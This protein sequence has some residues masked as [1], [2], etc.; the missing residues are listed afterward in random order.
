L[1][2]GKYSKVRETINTEYKNRVIVYFKIG[3]RAGSTMLETHYEK[4]TSAF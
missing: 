1:N 4:W 3:F 2:D